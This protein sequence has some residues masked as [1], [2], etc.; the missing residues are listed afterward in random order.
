M[1]W[2]PAGDR[3]IVGDKEYTE[4][5]SYF[6]PHHVQAALDFWL[7]CRAGGQRLLPYAGAVA[8]QPAWMLDV[9]TF[10]DAL[11]MKKQERR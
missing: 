6:I 2:P 5:P 7:K 9:F 1:P 11:L 8:D 3:W 4:N 10:L